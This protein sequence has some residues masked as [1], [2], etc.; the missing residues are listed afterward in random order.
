MDRVRRSWRVPSLTISDSTRVDHRFVRSP[1]EHVCSPRSDPVMVTA[2]PESRDH[3]VTV[4]VPSLTRRL[5]AHTTAAPALD[6]AVTVPR[7]GAA[8]LSLALTSGLTAWWRVPHP[9]AG[10][11]TLIVSLGILREPSQLAVLMA[12]VLLLTVQGYV[13]NRLAGVPYPRWRPAPSP[14]AAS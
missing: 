11:T 4:T 5:R 13:I 9:P 6:T 10:A 8:A 2:M 3:S 7:I 1:R 14:G 12:A